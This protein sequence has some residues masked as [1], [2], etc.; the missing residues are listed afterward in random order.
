L[1]TRTREIVVSKTCTREPLPASV[2]EHVVPEQDTMMTLAEPS[3]PAAPSA[4]APSA[5]AVPGE[6]ASPA[7]PPAP[8]EPVAPAAP[9]A[10]A[11]P[12]ESAAPAEALE[13]EEAQ[14]AISM[15]SSSAGA[16]TPM[17]RGVLRLI[18]V[19]GMTG[20]YS[21]STGPRIPDD[22]VYVPVGK[23]TQ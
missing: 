18:D 17:E 19:H 11:A 16:S 9:A 2:T 22:A 5:P 8:G 3:A 1:A 13:L 4:P 14:P 15:T 23:P 10:P 6:P 12:G 20:S 7:A 21:G